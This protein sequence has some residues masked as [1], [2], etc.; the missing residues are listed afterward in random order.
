MRRRWVL[1]GAVSFV[2]VAGVMAT[3][4]TEAFD[5]Q[6]A[7]GTIADRFADVTDVYAFMR[8][9]SETDGGFK[10]TSHLVLAM[11]F[12]PDIQNGQRIP[13]NIDYVFR[14]R[15]VS[16]V[17]SLALGSPN[18]KVTCN[19]TAATPQKLVCIANGKSAVT[20]VGESDA[21]APTEGVRV[22]AGVRSD[23]AF[24]DVEAFRNTVAAQKLQFRTPGQNT[25]ANKN[26]MSIVVDLDLA[27]VVFNGA[28]SMPVFAVA[29]QTVRN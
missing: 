18:F 19:F 17:S 29:A 3:S 1:L 11:N 13:T 25:F 26:V 12:A 5:H 7:P 15:A 22:F 24:A 20:T 16:N 27:T 23:P 21:G 28:S 14:V 2:A 4:R 10:K 6:D 9:E 8:P